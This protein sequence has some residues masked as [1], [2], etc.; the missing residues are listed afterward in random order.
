LKS[1]K[2]KLDRKGSNIISRRKFLAI[3]SIAAGFAAAALV[4]PKV[5]FTKAA[6]ETLQQK[7]TATNGKWVPTACRVCPVY[8]AVKVKVVDGRMVKIEGCTRDLSSNGYLCAKGQSGLW[9]ATDPYRVKK[10]LKR[11]NPNKG[12]DEDPRFVEISWDE[13]YNT[14]ADEIKKV[15]AKGKDAWVIATISGG[16]ALSFS[17]LGR[18]FAQAFT[19]G[20]TSVEGGMNWCGHVAHYLSRVGHGGFT[21]R[22]DYEHC[23]YLIQFGRSHGLEGGA[24][25]VPAAQLNSDAR[26]R[27]MKIVHFD[28]RLGNNAAKADEWVP[29]IP[30]TDGAI[31]SAMINVLLHELNI[32]DVEFVKKHTNGPYLIGPDGRYAKEAEKALVWDAVEGKAKA[33][34]DETVTDYALEGSFTVNGVEVKPSFQLLKDSVKDMTPEWASKISEAPAE[35]IRRIAKEYAAAAQIGSTIVLDGVEHPYRPACTDYYGGN[36]SNHLHGTANGWS[37]EVLNTIMGNQDVPGG[38]CGANARGEAKP[39]P[40]GMLAHPSASYSGAVGPDRQWHFEFP[41]KTPEL[42]E[43]FPLGD[44]FG[45]VANV[46]LG[47]PDKF[48]G[49]GKHGVDMAFFHATNPLIGMYDTNMMH[50]IYG[51]IPFMA[52]ICLTIEETAQAYADIILPDRCYLEEYQILGGKLL[53]PVVDPPYDIPYV[54]ET[55]MEISERAGILYG[56]MGFNGITNRGLRPDENKLD[57]NTRYSTEEI[58][59]RLC[60][61]S[62]KGKGLEE[63]KQTGGSKGPMSYQWQP[64]KRQGFRLPIYVEKHVEM[65]EALRELIKSHMAE[66]QRETGEDW[67]EK[68]DDFQPL[69]YWK[70]SYLHESTPPYDLTVLAY[71]SSMHTFCTTNVLPWISETAIQHDPYMNYIWMNEDTAKA[72]GIAHGDLIWLEAEDTGLPAGI[73]RKLKAYASLSQG[74]HPNVIA[75]SRN[76][77]GWGRNSIVRKMFEKN[78]APTLMVVRPNLIQYIDGVT[79]ALEN[80]S[81]VRVYKAEVN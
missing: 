14:I 29:I 52:Y 72:K 50:E 53:Q 55:F 51:N 4:L 80:C 56:P 35:T 54:T 73:E 59:D 19:A 12:P 75:I 41:P 69:P 64:Y 44:H 67:N 37:I 2:N 63:M 43:L 9:F 74:I 3:T 11:T 81:K 23:N 16:G 25:F 65:R 66:I 38:H 27:G 48:W 62:F 21:T 36:A 28:P 79:D 34:D 46:V 76:M 13:A 70:S 49:I 30:A 20:V 57:V 5:P 47:N 40:D 24:N 18:N 45:A 39:G 10:P 71:L 58:F 61:V 1:K 31:A 15:K 77:G 22:V 33:F 26:A 8:D 17:Q 68:L 78:L 7:V 32:Y 60:K 6:T 42:E